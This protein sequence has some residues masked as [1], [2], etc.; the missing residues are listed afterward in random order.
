M[1]SD[2]T[3]WIRLAQDKDNWRALV[4]MAVNTQVP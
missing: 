4:Y 3:F 1:Q 2:D